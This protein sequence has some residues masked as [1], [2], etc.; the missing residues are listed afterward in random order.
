MDQAPVWPDRQIRARPDGTRAT[1]RNRPY[2]AVAKRKENGRPRPQRL[3]AVALIGRRS[4]KCTALADT[5]TGTQQW[6]LTE[7]GRRFGPFFPCDRLKKCIWD[8]ANQSLFLCG[9]LSRWRRSARVVSSVRGSVRRRPIYSELLNQD[10]IDKKFP[11]NPTFWSS[12]NRSANVAA[13]RQGLCWLSFCSKPKGER[14]KAAA[15][16]LAFR[17]C[18]RKRDPLGPKEPK[19]RDVGKKG[20]R[21]RGGG[22]RRQMDLVGAAA[23]RRPP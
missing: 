20:T 21:G 15:D 1:K 23:S 9:V 13:K 17:V 5:R 16:G 8:P 2:V 12:V 11:P 7:A 6:L 10:S 4:A 14:G 22:R 3:Q 18:G 19:R